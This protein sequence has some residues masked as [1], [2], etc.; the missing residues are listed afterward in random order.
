VAGSRLAALFPG[1]SRATTNSIHHQGIKSLAPGFVVEA[2]CPEDG[3]IEAIRWVGPSFVAGVQWHPEFHDPAHPHT[4]DDRPMLA[5][6]LAA[7]RE[8]RAR[9]QRR[10]E[11]AQISG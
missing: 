3:L 7:A 6:F 2:L 10:T 8:A 1:V 5:D 11:D 4:L 9:P